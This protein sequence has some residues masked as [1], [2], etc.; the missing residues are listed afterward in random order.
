MPL[1]FGGL[2]YTRD[3]VDAEFV[4]L[5]CT[6]GSRAGIFDQSR[7]NAI[8]PTAEEVHRAAEAMKQTELSVAAR[9]SRDSELARNAQI[10]SGNLSASA[11][12]DRSQAMGAKRDNRMAANR[13][14]GRG[15]ARSSTSRAR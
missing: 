10:A 9:G 7:W 11:I 15:G 2:T 5:F 14:G 8:F 13:A 6:H 3:P 4:E 12:Q 1:H